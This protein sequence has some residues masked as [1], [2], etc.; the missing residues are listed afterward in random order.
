V[1]LRRVDEQTWTV[2]TDAPVDPD[3]PEPYPHR[4]RITVVGGQVTAMQQYRVDRDMPEPRRA[5]P[6]VLESLLSTGAGW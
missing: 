4:T 3:G 1:R 6:L 5:A 2:T